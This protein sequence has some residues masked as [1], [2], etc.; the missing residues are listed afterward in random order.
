MHR[1]TATVFSTLLAATLAGCEKYE[2]DRQMEALCKKD[3]GVMVYEAVHLPM[4][5]FDATGRLTIGPAQDR[6]DGLYVQEVSKDLRIERRTEVIK[7]G[8][9]FGKSLISEGRVLRF[10]TRVVRAADNKVLGEEITYS[11]SGGEISFGHP[12]QN[13]CPRPR[14][15]P[16]VVQA[17]ILKGH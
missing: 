5:L 2:L 16:D 12:S 15:A 4:N 3:G 11:R 17:V 10:R 9:P 1:M 13:F 14:P 6:G 8:D 7:A